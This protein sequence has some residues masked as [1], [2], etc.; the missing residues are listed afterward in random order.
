AA[1]GLGELGGEGAV[2]EAAIGEVAAGAGMRLLGPNGFGLFVGGLGLNLMAW[3]DLPA[4]RVALVTQSGNLA[5]ALSRLMAHA[6]IGLASCTGLGNQLDL[7][8]ADIVAHHAADP[9][10]DAVAL[11]LEGLR[12]G[13][14][15][16][17]LAALEACRDRGKPVVVVKG[18]RS[19]AGA[20]AAA[21]H[22][23]ALSGDG[24]LWDAALDAAGAVTVDSPEAMVDVLAALAALGARRA[25]P[26]RGAPAAV[27]LTDGGGDSV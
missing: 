26:G 4:G 2:Q 20:R 25:G 5:I 16:R 1:A 22:T 18:G 8:A 11:Y 24:R 10:S 7:T 13:E 12:G 15:R 9:G 14:G 21:T 6:G 17:L 27:V 3:R 23:G 19:A